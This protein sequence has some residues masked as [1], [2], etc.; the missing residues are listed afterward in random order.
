MTDEQGTE[1]VDISPAEFMRRLRPELYSDST[2][3]SRYELDRATLEYHLETLTSRNQTQAFEIFAR[4]LCE[5]TVCPNLRPATGPEGGG[6]SKADTETLPLADELTTLLYVAQANAGRERWAFAFSAKERWADKARADVAAAMGTGRNYQKVFFVTSRFARSKDRARLEDEL[7]TKHG[8]QVTILDR[9]W[10]VEQVIDNDHRDLAFNYLGV[11]S[12]DRES[13]LGPNDYSRAQQL[14]EL[15]RTLADPQAFPGASW[16]RASEALAAAKLSR[17]LERPRHETDGR[18]SRAIRLATSDG[19]E[20]QQLEARYESIWTAFWWFSDFALV[21]SEYAGFEQRVLKSEHAK[22]LEFLG[23]LLQLLFNAVLHKQAQPDQV[24]LAGRAARLRAR[25]DELAQDLAR[26]NNALEAT[27]SCLVIVANEALLAGDPNQLATVWPRLSAVLERADGLGEFDAMRAVRFV[28]AMGEIAGSD[29][30]YSKLYDQMVDFVS[31]RKSEAEGALMLL[32]RAKQIES[33]RNFEMIRLLGRAVSQLVKREHSDALAEATQLLAL[34]YRSAGLL[35]AARAICLFAVATMFADAEEESDLPASVVPTLMMLAWIA[36]ELQD[37]PEV[38]QAV[39]LARGC[40]RGLP[41]TE[42]SR[43]HFDDRLTTFDF[44]FSCLMLNAPP[45]WLDRMQRLPDVLPGLGLPHSRIWLLYALGHEPALRAEGSILDDDPPDKVRSLA[46]QMLA[47]VPT[48]RR[49]RQVLLN[50]AVPG[51]CVTYVSGIRVAV[52]HQG[53]DPSMLA[54]EALLAAI[55][56]VFATLP[57]QDVFPHTQ[58]F[59]LEI[60]EV[61]DLAQPRLDI[62]ADR[63]S[64]AVSWPLD[65]EPAVLAHEGRLQG[66]LLIIAGNILSSTCFVRDLGKTLDALMLTDAAADRVS[67]VTIAGNSRSR[68]FGHKVARLDTW[69]ALAQKAYPLEAGRPSLDPTG[70]LAD[71][72]TARPA[73]DR[74]ADRQQPAIPTDHRL[75]KAHS[76]IDIALWDQ[77]RWRGV[78][79][80]IVGHDKPP[81]IGLLFESAPAARAIFERWRARLGDRDTKDALFIGIVRSL[82]NAPSAHYRVLITSG[83]S[84]LEEDH[85]PGRLTSIAARIQTMTPETD[86]NVERFLQTYRPFG[87]YW[88]VP[89][90]L[91]PTGRPDILT[92]LSIMKRHLVVKSAGDIGPHDIEA[93]ALHNGEVEDPR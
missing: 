76:L 20:Y 79:F 1:Q 70:Y 67:A 29:P 50:E 62:S 89:A 66:S 41:L 85:E 40:A 54:A 92:D 38:L 77:A 65:V 14:D 23:N 15:E 36:V 32:K 5:R 91:G 52:A 64:G 51:E 34:A 7:S 72:A 16:Q 71:A 59:A 11:G 58:A 82:P 6:D 19:T 27:F 33:G 74:A 42:A 90:V 21:A 80:F 73:A 22:V 28:E 75:L 31:R 43:A 93:I 84:G 35:W 57:E 12:E 78:A 37:V 81:V 18:F 56:V 60:R 13:R 30:G 87:T 2:M 4:K 55:E 26:P 83:T 69:I 48:G 88:L 10:I 53:S 63:L 61:P 39:R 45:D 25:L 86:E 46:S 8:V 49:R 47:Q 9:T 68:V 17:S 24:D 3:R 44:V